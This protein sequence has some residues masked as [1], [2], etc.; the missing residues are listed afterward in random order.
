MPHT[1]ACDQ[2]ADGVRTNKKRTCS[3][4]ALVRTVTTG[5]YA[6]AMIDPMTHV[7]K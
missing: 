6:R 2:I 1:V 7:L 4:S 5:M 3:G